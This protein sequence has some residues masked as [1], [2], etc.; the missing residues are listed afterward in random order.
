M[1]TVPAP[2][3]WFSV[4][5]QEGRLVILDQRRLPLEEVYVALES[6]GD[7]F[8]AI[9]DLMVRGAPAI[10]LVAA[11]G[12]VLAAEGSAAPDGPAL[13]AELE[14]VAAELA[15]A[16]PTAVNLS[17]ALTRML[18]RARAAGAGGPA[19]VRAALAAEAA[20]IQAEDE[21]AGRAMG[22]HLL[23]LLPEGEAG[24]LTHCNAGQ[25]ATSRY[26]TALAPIYLGVERG[27]RFRVYADE[28]RP[29][30]Q[31]S[32]LTAWELARL[33]VDTTLI[34]DDMAASVLQQGKVD[35]VIVGADR[36]AANGD[37]ANKIGTLG[38]ALMARYFGVPFYVAAPLSTV[39]FALPDGRAIP[40]EERPPEEVT[41]GLGRRIAPPGVKVYNPAFDVTPHD[42]I[43]AIV[44]ERGVARPPLGAALAR[45]AGRG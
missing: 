4:R 32:R 23:A 37:T 13:V 20:A 3:T 31:G 38:V 5:W 21:A 41:E 33:G 40:I 43:T 14:A 39:D 34:C 16:R 8:Q 22:E 29:V 6:P 24:I 10:G 17:W 2:A 7:V 9:R 18:A 44:T 35:A 36:I 12:L 25:L 28:T 11:W 1:Q 27:R 42:L 45:L 15:T 26:G 19:A 30:L